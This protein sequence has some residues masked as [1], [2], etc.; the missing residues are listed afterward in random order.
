MICDIHLLKLSA[1]RKVP[2]TDLFHD[3]R[4]QLR[5]ASKKYVTSI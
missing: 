4:T 5:K 2:E 3:V 1:V